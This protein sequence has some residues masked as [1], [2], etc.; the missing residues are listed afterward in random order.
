MT[1]C[2]CV[3]ILWAFFGVLPSG[4]LGGW[5]TMESYETLK[6]CQRFQE[7]LEATPKT[8]IINMICLPAGQ[9]PR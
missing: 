4:Q 7:R 1:T 2:T 5:T 9:E 3:F 8:K 6:A